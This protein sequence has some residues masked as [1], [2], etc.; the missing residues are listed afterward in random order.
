MSSKINAET[1]LTEEEIDT[2]KK[3]S[4]FQDE[5][6]TPGSAQPAVHP[7]GDRAAQSGPGDMRDL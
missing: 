1:C 6:A 5:Q 7:P 3:G 4:V 2:E